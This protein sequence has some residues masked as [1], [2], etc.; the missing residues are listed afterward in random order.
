MVFECGPFNHLY[1][2]K[3]YFNLIST[4][5]FEGVQKYSSD[6]HKISKAVLN[7]GFNKAVFNGK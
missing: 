4:G 5:D 7:E 2:N 3:F 1:K 6:G